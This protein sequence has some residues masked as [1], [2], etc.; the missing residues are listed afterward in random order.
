MS[1]LHYQHCIVP[2]LAR[3]LYSSRLSDMLTA[4][5]QW[6]LVRLE[7]VFH[8]LH[9]RYSKTSRSS[10]LCKLPAKQFQLDPS[11]TWLVKCAADILAPVI[12]VIC[13]AS[14]QQQTFQRPC[15]KAI[16][17]PLLKKRNLDSNDPGS[18]QPISNLSFLS[19]VVEKVVDD[20]I[21]EHI[22]RHRLLPVFQSAYQQYHSTAQLKLKINKKIQKKMKPGNHV[23][24]ST[25]V[26]G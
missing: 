26:I 20:I 17:T 8:C 13:N 22:N 11:P 25:T 7:V 5:S 1:A 2:L 15:K 21:S 16:V 4:S 23:I 3:S 12:N 18:Y 9:G 19:K 24:I 6:V 10:L 14:F